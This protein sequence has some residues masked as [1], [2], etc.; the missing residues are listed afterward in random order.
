MAIIY[1]KLRGHRL[2]LFVNILYY[3]DSEFQS[4]FLLYADEYPTDEDLKKVVSE[5]YDL[6]EEPRWCVLSEL[7]KMKIKRLICSGGNSYDKIFNVLNFLRECELPKKNFLQWS[8]SILNN[9]ERILKS[10]DQLLKI[11][12]RLNSKMRFLSR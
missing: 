8:E 7:V 10:E 12:N 4:R 6:F 2:Y 11:P 1:E 3:L 5:I 9:V